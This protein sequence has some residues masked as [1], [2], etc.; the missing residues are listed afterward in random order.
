MGRC[1][2]RYLLSQAHP[3]I[4]PHQWRVTEQVDLPPRVTGPDNSVIHFSISHSRS[5]LAVAV[6]RSG[7]IGVDIEQVRQRE[8]RALAQQWFHPEEAAALKPLEP[9]QLAL[10]FYRL[11]T[12]KEAALKTCPSA[13][14]VLSGALARWQV[15]EEIARAGSD[16]PADAVA[17]D[18]AGL[19]YC[20]S[21]KTILSLAGPHLTPAG[22]SVIGLYENDMPP[23]L[24]SSIRRVFTAG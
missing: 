6:S 1:A 4:A 8:F 16:S 9:Q 24:V 5:L 10:A 23:P 3:H 21:P 20:L 14:G 12:L 7:P 19:T 22:V 2:L 11:W 18:V 13:D 17:S 15:A